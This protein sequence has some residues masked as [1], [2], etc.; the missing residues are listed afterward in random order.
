ME[1]LIGGDKGAHVRDFVAIRPPFFTKGVAKGFENIRVGW[2]WGDERSKML[3]SPVPKLVT[4]S[5]GG[6]LE[7]GS[8][9]KRS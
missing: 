7:L 5:V 1:D 3:V 8:S 2:E 9:R 4:L 6:M